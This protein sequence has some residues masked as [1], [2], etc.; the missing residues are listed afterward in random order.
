MHI[1]FLNINYLLLILISY[2]IG[3]IPSAILISKVMKTKDPR[4]F[5]SNNPGTTNMLRIANKTSAALTLIADISKGYIS[6]QIT[7]MFIEDNSTSVLGIISIAVILGHIYPIFT[8]FIGGKGV[9]TFLGVL[10]NINPCLAITAIITW[11]ISAK[12]SGYSSLA[13]IIT[14]TI[15]PVYY[16]AF[17]KNFTYVEKSIFISLVIISIIIVCRHKNNIYNLLKKV[18]D[19]ISI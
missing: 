13:S 10:L 8:K 3:S 14:V 6:L 2:L 16:L 5:G 12:I 1:N 4:K 18:E 17:N 15:T 19:K 7:R 9:A 11:I